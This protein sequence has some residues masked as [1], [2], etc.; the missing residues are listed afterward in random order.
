MTNW[1]LI[2][3]VYKAG[4]RRGA[5]EASSYDWGCSATGDEYDNLIEALHD[6]W[7]AGLKY[8]DPSYRD[9]DSVKETVFNHVKNA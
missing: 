4:I 1:D 5:D 2:K 6:Y 9:W 3:L 8:D 7:N